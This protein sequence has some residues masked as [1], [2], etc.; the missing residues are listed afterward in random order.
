M[1]DRSTRRRGGAS[2]LP[3]TTEPDTTVEVAPAYQRVDGGD[4][5]QHRHAGGTVH[6][7]ADPPHWHDGDQI[8]L[9]HD[10]PD[11]NAPTLAEREPYEPPTLDGPD[12]EWTVVQD[13]PGMRVVDALL[14]VPDAPQVS[15]EAAGRAVAE[16]ERHSL[17]ANGLP[18]DPAERERLR[19]DLQASLDYLNGTAPT[20]PAL[21]TPEGVS[22]PGTSIAHPGALS[23]LNTIHGVTDDALNHEMTWHAILTPLVVEMATYH[24]DQRAEGGPGPE[25]APLELLMR[26]RDA[27]EHIIQPRLKA[28]ERR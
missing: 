23:L 12:P 28:Q 27:M 5:D 21:P 14:G 1:T 26:A 11:P 4:T 15:G 17:G 25:L 22:R 24:A 13:D 2:S 8:V 19:G 10:Y 6:A 20:T 3:R 7:H 9:L 18:T 16:A